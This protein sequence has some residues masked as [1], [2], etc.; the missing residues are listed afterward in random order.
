MDSEM[1]EFLNLDNER[2][3]AAFIEKIGAFRVKKE[4]GNL[5]SIGSP[6]SVLNEWADEIQG[7][8]EDM[9]ERLLRFLKGAR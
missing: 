8:T 6:E 9:L 2:R 1:T 3:I 4:R 7:T 5:D